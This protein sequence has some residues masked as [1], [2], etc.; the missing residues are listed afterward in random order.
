M[1]SK[2]AAKPKRKTEHQ[3]P[4]RDF[5]IEQDFNHGNISG[6]FWDFSYL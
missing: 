2:A 6:P 4:G 5:E 1:K 3:F